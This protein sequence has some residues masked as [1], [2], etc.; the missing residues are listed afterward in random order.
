LVNE[1]RKEYVVVFFLI[2]AVF[3]AVNRRINEDFL[4]AFWKL[5]FFV[6][7]SYGCNVGRF[8]RVVFSSFGKEPF[9]FSVF[10]R[11]DV[12][13]IL[14]DVLVEFG[15][16]IFGFVPFVNFYEVFFFLFSHSFELFL[17]VKLK[18]IK[19]V[20]DEEDERN[21]FFPLYEYEEGFIVDE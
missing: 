11:L 18:F 16:E 4:D 13:F 12:V 20:F 1:S 8:G 21:S 7:F 14:F 3:E 15:V 19:F 9:Q 17:R 2:S 10:F 5:G 6:E